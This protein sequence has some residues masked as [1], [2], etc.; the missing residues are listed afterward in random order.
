[1]KTETPAATTVESSATTETP[2][3]TT[4]TETT[5][6]EVT[7][8]ETQGSETEALATEH[9]TRDD[10][11][12]FVFQIDPEN[13]E[14]SVYTGKTLDELLFNVKK[15]KIEADNTIARMKAQGFSPKAGKDARVNGNAPASTEVSAPDDGKILKEVLTQFEVTAEMLNW[16]TE[17]WL[18]NEREHGAV[19]TMELKQAV[20]EAKALINTRISEE[21][22]VYVNN[23]NL[24]NEVRLA[25]ETLV[26]NNITPEQVNLDEVIER[27][28]KNPRYWGPNGM[29]VPGAIATELTKELTKI[30]AKKTEKTV[31]KKVAFH[32][33]TKKTAAPSASD[34]TRKSKESAG[35][36]STN[37]ALR[38]ILKEAKAKG[39]M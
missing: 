22:V 39:L 8:T 27:V 26:E 13:P 24:E 6:T 3:E 18:E 5:E 2:Q 11:G 1:M 19:A 25:V 7:E 29:R 23:L 12:N 34:T 35:L 21:N 33:P 9:I 10:E 20:R 31:E 4:T 16:S 32:V 28:Q 37:D 38:D 30:T 14:S 15:G 17:Q 36:Q